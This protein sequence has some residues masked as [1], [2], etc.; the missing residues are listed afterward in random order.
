M[1]FGFFRA[2]K[3]RKRLAQRFPRTWEDVLKSLPFLGA[4]TRTEN[5]RL[6]DVVRILVEEK[7]WEGCGGLELTDEMKVEIAA[8][9]ARLVLG[10]ED[11]P[12]PQV[13]GVLVYP[14][15]FV[16]PP[17]P[18]TM[19]VIVEAGA[20]NAG[21]AWHRGP[22]VLSWDH[23]AAEGCAAG[24]AHNVVIHEF[25]HALDLEDG[26]ADG[27]PDLPSRAT[28][29]TWTQVMAEEYKAL[30]E[31]GKRGE[32]T[33]L[34]PYGAT[35]SAEFFAVAT[36]TFFGIPHRLRERHPSLYDVLSRFYRQDPAARPET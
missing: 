21:E 14:T 20:V 28:Y 26:W 23:V 12:F 10:H 25:A 30:V 11:E 27:T 5:R 24:T 6:H 15:A 29:R 35:N 16:V 17:R 32:V 31:A 9:A 13:T 4:L 7:R 19:G 8:Q 34:D 18:R 36:E 1:V 33:L 22:I 2:W 3:R